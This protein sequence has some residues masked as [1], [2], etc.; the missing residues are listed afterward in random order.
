VAAPEIVP[1]CAGSFARVSIYPPLVPIACL[2]AL[3]PQWLFQ[4][5]FP[6]LLYPSY[7]TAFFAYDARRPLSET[8][9]TGRK[10]VPP[11]LTLMTSPTSCHCLLVLLRFYPWQ[12]PKSPILSVLLLG[13]PM[14]T[15]KGGAHTVRCRSVRTPLTTV[16]RPHL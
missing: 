1:L 4:L 14:Q 16:T 9:A 7:G 11:D 3:N 13:R 2:P 15:H 12:T 8:R 10:R 5:F 6:P